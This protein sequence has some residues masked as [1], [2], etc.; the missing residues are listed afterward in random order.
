MDKEQPNVVRLSNEK[1]HVVLSLVREKQNL[2]RQLQEVDAALSDLATTYG[3][4]TAPGSERYDLAVQDGQVVLWAW[5][6]EEATEQPIP[7]E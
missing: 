6:K 4:A 2:E 5:T 7:A 3:Q 1:Q